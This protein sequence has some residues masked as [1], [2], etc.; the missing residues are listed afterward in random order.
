MINLLNRLVNVGVKP[1]YQP[2]EI[3]LTRKLNLITCITMC[4]M[5]I[6][7]VFF[8]ISGYTQIFIDC[9]VSLIVLPFL[10]LLNSY[11]KQLLT[12]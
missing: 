7:L 2:W 9:L 6:A 12:L 5:M 4:N 10:I 8:Q 3:Y 1:R 11:K